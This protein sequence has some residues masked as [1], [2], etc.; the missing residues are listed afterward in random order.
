M[1]ELVELVNEQKLTGMSDIEIIKKF[2]VLNDLE[3]EAI[4]LIGYL[5][6]IKIEKEKQKYDLA[7]TWIGCLPSKYLYA[8]Y[9]LD[10][11]DHLHGLELN[12][13]MNGGTLSIKEL[14][15]AKENVPNIIRPKAYFNPLIEWLEE[16][17][18][19]FLED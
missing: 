5:A 8:N 17:G 9:D 11:A 6:K 3:E 1:I 18:I 12:Y 13:L 19:R 2:F 10:I 14:E 4:D 7:N 15:R 16:R